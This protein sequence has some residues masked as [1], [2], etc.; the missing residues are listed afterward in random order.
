MTPNNLLYCESCKHYTRH[1]F[2]VNVGVCQVCIGQNK[3]KK[4]W[5]LVIGLQKLGKLFS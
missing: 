1:T 4:E 3:P 5:D 2:V